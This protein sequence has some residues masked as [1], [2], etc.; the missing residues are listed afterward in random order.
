[1]ALGLEFRASHLLGKCFITELQ[2]PT[3]TIISLPR[4]LKLQCLGIKAKYL[5]SSTS[6]FLTRGWVWLAL[7]AP[8][9][10]VVAVPA[11]ILGAVLFRNWLWGR[12]FLNLKSRVCAFGWKMLP[13]LLFWILFALMLGVLRIT[14]PAVKLG[15]W[16]TALELCRM[17]DVRGSRQGC[18]VFWFCLMAGRLLF[19]P[20]WSKLGWEPDLVSFTFCSV[21]GC[22][23]TVVSFGLPYL[24]LLTFTSCVSLTT[25]FFDVRVLLWAGVNWE[26]IVCR[27]FSLGRAKS[28]SVERCCDF[29]AWVLICVFLTNCLL[30]LS[31]RTVRLTELLLKICLGARLFW[32]WL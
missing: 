17:R 14:L 32:V 10:L 25:D 12:T 30:A 21:V 24:I 8:F 2:V 23:C 28:A 15:L 9:L 19:C 3:P 22:D 18:T 31:F 4:N 26:R 7:G 1:M 16:L 20:P 11:W 27:G 5:R 29:T 13:F 6:V